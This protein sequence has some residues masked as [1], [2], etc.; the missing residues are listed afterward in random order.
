MQTL[1]LPNSKMNFGQKVQCWRYHDIGLWII[2]QRHIDG[3][4]IYLCATEYVWNLPNS[5][6]IF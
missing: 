2:L 5:I 4:I 3:Q 6:Y 1:N